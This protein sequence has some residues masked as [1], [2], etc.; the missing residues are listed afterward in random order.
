LNMIRETGAAGVEGVAAGRAVLWEREPPSWPAVRAASVGEERVRLARAIARA[1]KG[2]ADLMLLLPKAEAELFEPELAILA[3]LAPAL[4]ARVEIGARG[5]DA[6]VDATM[7]V[8]NDLVA[9]ARARLLDS[10]ACD[11]RSVASLLEGRDGERVLVATNLTPSVVAAL[12]VRVVGIVAASDTSA[13]PGL[14]TA[15]HAAILARERAIPLVFVQ[16]DVIRAIGNDDLVLL[17]TATAPA[18]VWVSPDEDLVREARTRK[19]GLVRARAQEEKAAAAPLSHLAF[20]VHVNVG[21]LHE[22]VPASADGIGLVRTELI[23]SDHAGAPSE[24]E[25]FGALRAIAAD[26]GPR[27]IV[28]RLFDAGGDK[29]LP[30]LRAPAGAAGAR[31]MELLSIHPEVLL[32]Q[33]RAIVRAARHSD[34]RILLP[35][36]AR[37]SDVQRIRAQIDGVLPVGAMI[38][39]PEAVARIGE[40]AAAADF[41]CI[42]TNDLAA[43]VSGYDRTDPRS[44]AGDHV[45][46]LIERVIGGC[47]AHKRRASVC[48]EIAGDPR[49]ARILVGLGADG[50]SVSL[51]CF[52]KVK[53]S[54]H[55]VSIEGCRS[56]AREALK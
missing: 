56:A 35:L 26:V 55:D 24:A 46:P 20:E 5:E 49:Y 2:I 47:H 10:L 38:E 19:E 22:R 37:A 32:T 21:S 48:G 30:W 18:T 11:E 13:R 12:P 28:V 16:S 36:V 51:A 9:D 23:F 50:V 14:A 31:G 41:V 17:D 6:V 25:Q 43:F 7:S 33:L 42:G 15:S 1:A 45:L 4:L 40:I 44:G 3:E 34:L 29:A 53:R 27:P 54:L 8:P 39:T 52:A